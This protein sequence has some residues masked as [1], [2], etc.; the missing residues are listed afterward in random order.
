MKLLITGGHV[1]PALAVIDKLLVAPEGVR[2]VFVGRKYSL[3]SEETLSL[4]YKEITKRNIPFR[5]LSAG[6]LT[7][8]LSLQSLVHL[9]KVPLGFIQA[10]SIMNE[11]SPQVVLSFGGYLALPIAIIAW[12]RRI[13]VYTHEQT[14]RPGLANRIIARFSSKVFYAFPEAKDYFPSEKAV[15]SG[16]P[17]RAS[18]FRV[19]KKPFTVPQGLPVIYVTGG[20]LG[21]HGINEHI[22]TLLPEL[23]KDFFVV[24]QIGSVKQYDDFERLKRFRRSLPDAF[25]DRYYPVEHFF[26]AEIGYVYSIADIVV[27]RAGANTFFELIHLHK[28][29]IFIPL[30]WSAHQEQLHHALFFQMQGIGELFEQKEPS[31]KLLELIRTMKVNLPAY[32][33]R[34]EGLPIQ[35]KKDAADIIINEIIKGS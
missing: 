20:S 3:E 28:P 5:A 30:P 9:F 12:V 4:E 8:V 33:K 21:S 24:H 25:K 22:K 14:I 15:L 27:G 32:K 1:T 23:L 11:E 6:R 18:I 31:E 17:V 2:I 10:Y 13:P 35:Y 16:N 7:R 19:D 34:F 26:D 29:A